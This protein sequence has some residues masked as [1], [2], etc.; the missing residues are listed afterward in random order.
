[1]PA[2]TKTLQAKLHKLQRQIEAVEE[3]LAVCGCAPPGGLTEEERLVATAK[4]AAL[5]AKYNALV[6]EMDH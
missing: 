3:E 4:L 5:R 6:A 2:D 1:M